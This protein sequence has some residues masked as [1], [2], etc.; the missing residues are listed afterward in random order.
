L[1]KSCIFHEIIVVL[2]IVQIVNV[3]IMENVF[4]IYIKQKKNH[5]VNVIED[6][7]ENFVQ[8]HIIVHVHLIHYVWEFLLWI[9]LYVFVLLIVWALDVLLQILAVKWMEKTHV[10]MEVNVYLITKF[11]MEFYDGI[12]AFV[13]KV[14]VDIFVSKVIIT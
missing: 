5:F 14:L 13:V 6:G 4:N 9:D 7:E 1:Q 12:V 8:F 2:N 11:C 3:I 10:K